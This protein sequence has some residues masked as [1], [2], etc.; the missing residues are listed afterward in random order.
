MIDVNREN[1]IEFKRVL[2]DEMLEEVKKLFL[3]YAQSLN[4]ELD[5]QDFDYE[6]KTLPGKYAQPEGA[7]I[8]AMVNGKVAGCVALRKIEESICEMK[9]LYVRDTLR[10]Y[11][12]GIGLIDAIINEAKNLNYSYLRLDTLPTM[13]K[14]QSLYRSIG[15]YEIEPYVFNPVEGTRFMELKLT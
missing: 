3:E 7:I 13:E 6:L 8:I 9:R 15:F 14:A 2:D 1:V 12:I 11:R 5:F 4:I 10:G